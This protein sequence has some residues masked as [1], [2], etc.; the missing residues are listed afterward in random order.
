MKKTFSLIIKLILVTLLLYGSVILSGSMYPYLPTNSFVWAIPKNKCERGDIA[1]IYSSALKT[2][3]NVVKRVVALPH[4]KIKMVAGSIYLNDT[5]ISTRLYSVEEALKNLLGINIVVFEEQNN[6]KKHLVIYH[7]TPELFNNPINNFELIL[8]D[9]QYLLL[10]DNRSNSKDGRF[11]GPLPK[12]NI[13]SRRI[14]IVDIPLLEI[15]NNNILL[16]CPRNLTLANL[17][18]RFE[19]PRNLSPRNLWQSVALRVKNINSMFFL[20]IPKPL[21]YRT[22]IYDKETNKFKLIPTSWF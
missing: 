16:Y 12:K 6:H 1:V 19:D 3:Y 17:G 11:Y 21:K 2:N 8:A 20:V 5:L 10:G 22:Y 18:K 14:I 13:V 9:D 7:K 4:D 15:K